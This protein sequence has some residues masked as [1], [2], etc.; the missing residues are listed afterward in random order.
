MMQL[1]IDVCK[2]VSIAVNNNQLRESSLISLFKAQLASFGLDFSVGDF[3]FFFFAFSAI[4]I[5]FMFG[6]PNW[7]VG[8]ANGRIIWKIEI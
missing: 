8:S 4:S 7:A 6:H 3:V 5:I 2:C 1:S